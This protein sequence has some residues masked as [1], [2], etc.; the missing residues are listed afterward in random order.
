MNIRITNVPISVVVPSHSFASLERIFTESQ[1]TPWENVFKDLSE[2][3]IVSIGISDLVKTS[4]F[5]NMKEIKFKVTNK[6]GRIY[7]PKGSETPKLS[8]QSITLEYIDGLHTTTIGNLL[9]SFTK[10]GWFIL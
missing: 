3:M 10:T 9:E 1:D 6:S 8:L 5:S 7:Y 4:P 2:G